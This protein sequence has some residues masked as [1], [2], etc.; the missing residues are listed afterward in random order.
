M[1]AACSEKGE[2]EERERRRDF[3]AV[4][5][6][7]VA[8]HRAGWDGRGCCSATFLMGEHIA[9]REHATASSCP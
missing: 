6:K 8:G 1:S 5:G 2:A 4:T 7:S 3:L 9:W